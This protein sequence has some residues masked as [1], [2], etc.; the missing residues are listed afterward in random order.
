MDKTNNKI[1]LL[2]LISL[3]ISS[4]P[5]FAETSEKKIKIDFSERFRFVS[6]DNNLDLDS[7]S[8][9]NYLFTRNRTSIGF[10]F[11]PSRRTELYFKVT[12]EFK[13]YF[14]PEGRDFNIN[15]IFVDNLY[16]KFKSTERF[17]VSFTVGRQN[18]IFGEGF[19]LMDGNP[20]DGS[21]SIFFDAV[22][23]DIKVKNAGIFSLLWFSAPEQDHF[24]PVI[25]CKNQVFNERASRGYGLYFSGN[26]F[27]TPVEIYFLRKQYL[28]SGTTHLISG[29]NILG[30]R[31]LNRLADRLILTT[32]AAYEFGAGNGYTISALGGYLYL[33]YS[34]KGKL[35]FLKNIKIGGIYLSGDN[36]DTDRIESW[37]PPFSRW[38]KWS[39][40]YIYAQIKEDGVAYWTNFSSLYIAATSELF[41]WCSMTITI[42]KFGALQKN[43][44]DGFPGGS[45]H[46]RGYLVDSIVKLN[47]K[48]GWSAHLG[49]EHFIP[50]SYYFEGADSYNW[51]RFQLVYK[52][53]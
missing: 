50:G 34:F 27:K 38:P 17:P 11:T 1:S 49:W 12:N 29:F 18:L 45:G 48:K 42:S 39:D 32:E 10:K 3:L 51:F 35:S 41:K 43:S 4:F 26:K 6:W 21:R 24:L 8:D 36:P 16:L 44:S 9:D 47:L 40:S 25:N 46:L 28:N 7:S 5:V 15:E 52:I 33:K 19:I 23:S 22:R 30:Y 14:K 31:M 2:I 20:L 13:Y 37:D 53:K